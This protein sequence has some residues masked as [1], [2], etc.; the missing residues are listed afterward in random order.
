MM[1][2]MML[3]VAAVAAVA[4]AAANKATFWSLAFG[5][6]SLL[7]DCVLAG[8]WAWRRWVRPARARRA[9]KKEEK[10]ED[11]E[12]APVVAN[13]E[14]A[15]ARYRRAVRHRDEILGDLRR[16]EEEVD[17]MQELARAEIA[18]ARTAI[19]AAD[20]AIGP[21]PPGPEGARHRNVSG[22]GDN[23]TREA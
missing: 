15:L 22:E 20:A 3:A 18:A 16:A 11:E 4:A 10:K 23:H 19:A 8:L 7:K 9:A 21:A 12:A 2:M 1:T 17:R 14:G 13:V 6:V 5:A